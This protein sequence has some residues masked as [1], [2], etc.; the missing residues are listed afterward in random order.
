MKQNPDAFI[1]IAKNLTNK[2]KL[3]EAE[4]LL[5]QQLNLFPEYPPLLN[6]LSK[7]TFQLGDYS[8]ANKYCK[9]LLV[10]NPDSSELYNRL[11][12]IHYQKGEFETAE[13]S[14]LKAIS[15]DPA[16]EK[17]HYLLGKLLYSSK[18]FEESLKMLHR[19][20]DIN[21]NATRSYLLAAKIHTSLNELNKA[22]SVLTSGLKNQPANGEIIYSL[23]KINFQLKDLKSVEQIYLSQLE[24]DPEDY[25]TMLNMG[26]LYNMLGKKIIA[27]EWF[28]KCMNSDSPIMPMATLQYAY[29]SIYLC[30]WGKYEWLVKKII[31]ATKKYIKDNLVNY[32]LPIYILMHFDVPR[33][34]YFQA[35]KKVANNIK[36]RISKND[37]PRLKRK[38]ISGNKIRLGYIS[39]TLRKQAGGI[40]YY[41]IFRHHNREKFEIFVYSMK[42]REDFISNHIQNTCDHFLICENMTSEAVAEKIRFDEIDI[43]VTTAGYYDDMRM[44]ILAFQPAPLQV[45]AQGYNESTG[46]DFIQYAIVDQ[47]IISSETQNVYTEK[48][49][50][51]PDCAMI[52]SPLPKVEKRQKNNFNLPEGSFVYASFNQPLK[53]TKNTIKIW[54]NILR[55]TETSIIWIYDSD[56]NESRQNILKEFEDQDIDSNRIYFTGKMTMENHWTRFQHADLYLDCFHYNA[57]ATAIEALRLGLPL[58]TLKGN[59]HNSRYAASILSDA[60][61]DEFICVT[62]QEYLNKAIYYFNHKDTLDNV[63]RTLKESTDIQLFNTSGK[64]HEFETAFLNIWGR[65]CNGLPPKNITL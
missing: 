48:L 38:P 4:R 57:Q 30:Q 1:N 16:N 55:R 35:A 20:M 13:S 32:D 9:Q 65:Y 11:G 29:N 12:Q 56:S 14:Y 42:H 53:I 31:Y 6:Q 27:N 39:S 17:A 5:V 46:S 62:E 59:T 45:I 64:V 49:I 10:N 36:Q 33:K 61:L 58:L 47:H 28:F 7:I 43:L 63:S 51:L 34:I 52:N 2:G 44:D 23:T 21:P 15:L 60:G 22:K 3:T 25:E 26:L 18:R 19:S 40:L 8:S 37:F 41:D 54:S 50:I 24:N